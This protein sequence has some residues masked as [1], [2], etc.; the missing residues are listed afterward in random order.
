MKIGFFDSGLGG[1]LMMNSCRKTYPQY[2]YLY[3]GD[4]LHLPYGPKTTDDILSHMEPYLLWLFEEKKCDYICVACNTAS[5]KALPLFLK[6]YPHYKIRF[7]DILQPTQ[8]FL[9]ETNKPYIILATEGT[10][11]SNCYNVSENI[12]QIS[13]PGLVELIEDY[14]KDEAMIM[15]NKVLSNYPDILHVFLACTHYIFLK[16][17]IEYLYPHKACIAQDIFI[18]NSINSINYHAEKKGQTE[19]FVSNHGHEYTKKYGNVF[20]HIQ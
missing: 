7:I 14:K 3:V 15:V 12:F 19:Y 17:E 6:K 13:M 11:A 16:K 5:V 20:T 18:K 2:D 8:D 1:L 10:V 4:T 9:R